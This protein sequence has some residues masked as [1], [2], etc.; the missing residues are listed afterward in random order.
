VSLYLLERGLSALE[1]AGAAAIA[2]HVLRLGGALRDGLQALGLPVL[3][4]ADPMGRAGNIAFATERP[5]QFEALLL[6]N[7]VIAWGGDRR[8]RLSI[9]GYNDEADVARALEVL[10]AAAT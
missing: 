7:G 10:R 9:H 6:A 5:G 8:L 1:R 4:P 2:D 3:T